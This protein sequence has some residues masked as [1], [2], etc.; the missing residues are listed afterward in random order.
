TVQTGSEVE[1]VRVA[2]VAAIAEGQVPEALKRQRVA[3]RVREVA[4]ELSGLRIVGVDLAV[5]Q[6]KIPDEQRAAEVPEILRGLRQPP[7][8]VHPP[9]RAPPQEVA[10]RVKGIDD[11]TMLRVRAIPVG[12]VESAVDVI[13]V[14]GPVGSEPLRQVRVR[15]DEVD[16]PRGNEPEVR[17][18]DVDAALA[19]VGRVQ[20][21]ARRGAPYVQTGTDWWR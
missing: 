16:R 18:E 20:E 11:P 12:H 8:G 6:A 7:G 9:R 10:V 21:V 19:R 14:E 4:E 17:V 1:R 5:A 2:T 3:V 15:E 13:D